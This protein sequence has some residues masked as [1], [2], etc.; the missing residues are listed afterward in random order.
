MLSA[1]FPKGKRMSHD[2][3]SVPDIAL[4]RNIGMALLA[5]TIAVGAICVVGGL[6]SREPWVPPQFVDDNAAATGLML[7][8]SVR[9]I[10]QPEE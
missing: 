8:Q 3:Q 5:L 2:A 1:L 6:K 10:S 7:K 4:L 9:N